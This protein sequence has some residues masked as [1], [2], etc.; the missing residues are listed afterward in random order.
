M[1]RKILTIGIAVYNIKEEYL[2]QCIE[3]VISNS[4]PDLEIIIADVN[5]EEQ[6]SRICREYAVSDGRIIYIKNT[7]NIGIGN[8][9]NMIIDRASGEWLFFVDGDDMVSSSLAEAFI[10]ISSEYDLIIFDKFTF[11]D[12]SSI[13]IGGSG[14]MSRAPI[15]DL[16]AAMIYNMALAALNRREFT[17][18]TLPN[19]NFNPGRACDNAYKCSFLK[20][21]NLR[22]NG[23]LK[24][25]EDSLFSAS[26]LLEKP[27]AAVYDEIMYYYRINPQ[28]VTHKYDEHSKDVTDNYL[29]AIK[30]FIEQSFK[31]PGSIMKDFWKYRCTGAISD[32]FERNIFH[33]Q[34]PNPYKARRK[35][36]KLLL[37]AEPY[38]TALTAAKIS[39]YEN[40]HMRLKLAL[41]KRNQFFLLNMCYKY[42]ILFRIYGGLRHRI[43]KFKRR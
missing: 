3:S 43:S 37:S 24:T 18:K 5:S 11:C 7:E 1:N 6:C 12:T 32:N 17:N 39:E 9:R 4:S 33:P 21:N 42:K 23:T 15:I 8:V 25:A 35:A 27:K 26:V 2:R 29:A 40:H 38:R 14:T 30:S 36:F 20:D 19:F 10:G 28:S 22:F 16:S 31:E 34:N 13:D 41:S